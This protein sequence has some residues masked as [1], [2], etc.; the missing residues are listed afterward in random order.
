MDH[1]DTTLP[2]DPFHNEPPN[3]DIIIYPRKFLLKGPDIAVSC[4]AMSVPGK[5]R[6]GCSQSSIG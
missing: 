3:T 1:P 2:G 6:N 5:Y 4:E